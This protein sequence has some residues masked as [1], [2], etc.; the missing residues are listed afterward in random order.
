M[1]TMGFGR[2]QV[3]GLKRVPAPPAINTARIIYYL[4]DG[5]LFQS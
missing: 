1:G 2:S 4:G 5:F 3:R